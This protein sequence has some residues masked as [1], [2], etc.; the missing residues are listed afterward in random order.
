MPRRRSRRPGA[1]EGSAKIEPAPV[2]SAGA[3]GR[4][5]SRPGSRRPCGRARVVRQKLARFTS[6]RRRLLL[7][8]S[9]L[10][11]GRAFAECENQVVAYQ[12][13]ARI[14][15]QRAPEERNRIRVTL[16]VDVE[17]PEPRRRLRISRGG[18][19]EIGLERR[20]GLVVATL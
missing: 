3:P 14:K 19:L 2:S 10:E 8:T 5:P 17:Q 12:W 15:S 6:E 11:L 18:E 7:L 20:L 9:L 1:G 4:P 16:L 13:K